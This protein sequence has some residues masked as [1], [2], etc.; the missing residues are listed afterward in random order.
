MVNCFC[1]VSGQNTPGGRS[2]TGSAASQQPA[3][4]STP[5][6]QVG[7]PPSRSSVGATGTPSQGA[8]PGG[9]S[10]ANFSRAHPGRATYHPIT[11][12]RNALNPPPPF[13]S[14]DTSQTAPV[15]TAGGVGAGGGVGEFTRGTSV[16]ASLFG[17]FA[18]RFSKR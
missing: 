18:N 10:S 2:Q 15:N 14:K 8:V 17:R 4:T 11:N 3:I 1:S 5:S 16:Q 6:S 9:P 7:S 12:H 13:S